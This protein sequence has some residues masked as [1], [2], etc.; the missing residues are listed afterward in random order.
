M[1]IA[2][3]YNIVCKKLSVSQLISLQ[4]EMKKGL[5]CPECGNRLWPVNGCF[6][7]PLCGYESCS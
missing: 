6:T 4:K 2:K 1:T 5:V 3:R 7:C